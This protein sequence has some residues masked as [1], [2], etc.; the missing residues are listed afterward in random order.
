MSSSAKQV[1]QS[2]CFFRRL[3]RSNFPFNVTGENNPIGS[4]IAA[5]SLRTTRFVIPVTSG[6]FLGFRDNVSLYLCQ[7]N[8]NTLMP[9]ALSS[10]KTFS[11][12]C[13]LLD[14]HLR[15]FMLVSENICFDVLYSIIASLTEYVPVMTLSM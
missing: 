15:M 1:S 3:W 7:I 6:H 13:S 8:P 11:V 2:S 4:N 14:A 12:T 9:S 10:S 5:I